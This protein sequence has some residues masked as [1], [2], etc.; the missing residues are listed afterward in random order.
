MLCFLNC[1][2]IRCV[3]SKDI[4]IS[5]LLQAFSSLYLPYL[6]WIAFLN[7]DA[8]HILIVSDTGLGNG[9]TGPFFSETCS[10]VRKKDKKMKNYQ[11]SMATWI[12]RLVENDLEL[13]V[14]Q[15]WCYIRFSLLKGYIIKTKT[16]ILYWWEKSFR[17]AYFNW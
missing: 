14:I 10:L 13:W 2:H 4:Q 11:Y 1:K 3:L 8:V 9:V 6:K 16:N 17:D 15:S 7:E 12:L 5:S